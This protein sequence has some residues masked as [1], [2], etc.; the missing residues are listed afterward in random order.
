MPTRAYDLIEVLWGKG[1]VDAN[2]IASACSGD[3]VWEDMRLKT[4]A[5]GKEEVYNLLQKQWPRGAAVQLDKLGAGAR[6]GGF[7]WTRTTVDGSKLGL[8]GTTYVELNDDGKIK[9]VKELAEP[10]VKPG[11]MMLKLLQAATKNV[12]RPEKNPTFVEETP[13]KCSEIVDYIWTR[14]YP[15]DAPVEEAL[16]FYDKDVIYQDF[17]YPEPIRGFKDVETFSRE[18]GDFPGIEFRIQDLSEGDVACCFTWRVTVNGKEG[19]QGISFYETDGNGKITYIR[20]TPAPT[21]RPVFGNLARLLRP[22]LRTFR[23]RKDM[24]DGIPNID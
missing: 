13:T 8:R 9:C 7:T 17:N 11:E 14:A 18:W 19:P 6:S 20:D 2:L 5:N 21:M 4:P 3:V 22:K 24:T 1:V 16:K 12:P 15:N 10:L 23:S